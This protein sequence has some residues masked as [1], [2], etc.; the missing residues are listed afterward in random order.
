MTIKC[1]EPLPDMDP[2][3]LEIDSIDE[4]L[5]RGEITAEQELTEKEGFP[6]WECEAMAA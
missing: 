4:V 5:E 1:F 3:D 6:C 2:I